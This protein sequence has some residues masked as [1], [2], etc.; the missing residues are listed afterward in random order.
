MYN[1]S[2]AYFKF[3][4]LFSFLGFKVS[5]TVRKDIY[6]LNMYEDEQKLLMMGNLSALFGKP[7]LEN[8]SNNHDE[9][10]SFTF[11]NFSLLLNSF[12]CFFEAFFSNSTFW[13]IIK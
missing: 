7:K 10:K 5:D 1:T 11:L 4:F 6:D 8:K 2:F 9:N 3:T 13:T 12:L